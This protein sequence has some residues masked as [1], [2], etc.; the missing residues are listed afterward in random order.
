MLQ[1]QLIEVKTTSLFKTVTL[2]TEAITSQILAKLI[3]SIRE[4]HK[5]QGIIS[6]YKGRGH[7]IHNIR[8]GTTIR[9]QT[10][11]DHVRNKSCK[12]VTE[13]IM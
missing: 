7:Q 8:D 13:T 1:E 4:E 6:Q 10:V 3:T 12:L 5:E 9:W 2:R 11:I